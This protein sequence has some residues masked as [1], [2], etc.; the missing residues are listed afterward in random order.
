MI[1]KVGCLFVLLV[2][3]LFAIPTLCQSQTKRV[4]GMVVND[5]YVPLSYAR[6]TVEET[7]YSVSTDAGGNFEI[8]FSGIIPRRQTLVVSF[9]GKQTVREVFDFNTVSKLSP[10]VLRELTLALEEIN[11]QPASGTQS[12]SS[13]L[14]NR[15]IIERYPSLSLN[16]LLNMLPNRRVM[17]PSVQEM[18]NL[19]LRGAFQNVTG[20]SRNVDELNNAFGIALIVDDIALNNNA[21]MQS[22]NPGIYGIGRANLSVAQGD[23]NL[24]GDRPAASL[25]YSGESAFGGID[26]RQIP[27]ENIESIEVISGVAPV[28]YGDISD[29]A[30]IVERQA[31]QT[32][33]FFRIQSRQNATSYGLSKGMLISPKLGSVNVDL[34]YV[35]SYADNRDKLKQYN[36][37]SSSLIWTVN[38]GGSDK[39]KQTLSTTYTKV[40]DGVNKDDDDPLSTIVSYGSWNWNAST[41]LSYQPNG[42]VFKR[43]GLNLGVQT[44]HQ[45]SYREYYYN[46]SYVLY[47][48]TLYTG[49]AEGKYATGQY[50][51]IDHVDGRP[52]NLTARLET[53]AVAYTQSIAHHINFGA[54]VDY[55]M[56][57]GLGRLSDPMLP[58]KHLG[59]FNERYYDFS[60]TRPVWN[61]G[62]YLEDQFSVPL[63]DKPLFVTAGVRWDI[64]NGHQSVSPRTNLNYKFRENLQVGLA[65]GI[66]FKAPSLAHLYPGPTFR[67]IVLLNAYNGL[68]NESTSR[69]YVHRHDPSNTELSS[70]FSQTLEFT[71]R[72]NSHQHFLSFNA[73]YKQNRDGINAVSEDYVV[74]LPQYEATA[75][76]GQKPIVTVTGVRNYLMSSS[77][78]MNSNDRNNLGFELMYRSPRIAAIYTSF[79][80]AGG[81]TIAHSKDRYSSS[82]SFN[83]NEIGLEDIIKGYFKPI[84]HKTYFSNGRIGTAT[85]FPRLR[86]VMEF[87]A[88]AQFFNFSKRAVSEYEPTAY[89]RRSFEFVDVNQFDSNNPEHKFLYDHRKEEVEK[90]N[91]TNNLFFCNFHFNL[92]KEI[93]KN[94]R[95][96]LNIYNF[97]DYRPRI[98]RERAA[99]VLVPNSAPNYGAQIT[100]KF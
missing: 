44:S 37:L 6:V 48:D 83:Q 40:L 1:K 86:L 90:E 80:M 50:T 92:A 19:T 76:S 78:L 12:N 35:N 94:L 82:M 42:D 63:R 26:L 64:Q 69:I 41:R 72:W 57:M 62:V 98:Y 32:P 9:L 36:R 31:G 87:T 49:I 59:A 74:Q 84:N 15:D 5:S 79:N 21:N 67:E 43:V 81:L 53:N 20:G 22:R 55:S 100:Y 99:T 95:L 38:Y 71:T 56:N 11:V 2:A 85:H 47:T 96:G 17:A 68:V 60:L 29:G 7:N 27:T 45:A 16:D 73:F 30:V 97:L 25:G 65:Y 23:Y 88:D 18:Q 34:S 61:I 70:Q 66:A 58:L 14:I 91:D 39:W 10:I 54:N 77:Q 28:R 75:V 33:A 93:N 13:L 46:D 8:T 52:L 89:F 24:S 3:T 4:T 51:A